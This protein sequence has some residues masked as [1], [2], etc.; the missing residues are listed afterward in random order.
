VPIT[1]PTVRPGGP[2]RAI[3]RLALVGLLLVPLVPRPI[4]RG[5]GEPPDHLVVS[6]VVT[7]AASASDEL[8]EL[9]NPT[10]LPLPLEGLELV[11]ASASG[12][13]VSRRAAWELGAPLVPA[14]GHVLVANQDGA[15]AAIADA[16]YASGIAATGGSV[17]IRIVGASSAIDAVGWGTATGALP[18]GSPAPAPA[19]GAS[20]ER[21]PGGAAGSAQDTGDNAADFAVREVPEPQNLAS[22]PTPSV[23]GDPGATPT[24]SP[25]PVPP[26]TQVPT[27]TP[28]ATTPIAAARALPDGAVATIE[29]VALAASDFHDGGGFVADASG[30]IAVLVTDGSFQRGTLLRVTGEVDDRFSQRTLRADGVAVVALGPGAEPGAQA[31]TTGGIGEAV[32]GRLVSVA[33]AVIGSA[34][35]LTSGVAYDLDDGTGPVR[36]LVDTATG[37]DTS[38]W[39]SGTRLDLVGVVGQRDSTG[40]G[41]SGYRVMPRD[42]ADVALVLP[43]SPSPGPSSPTASGSPSPEPTPA[44]GVASIATARAAPKNARVTVRGVVTLPTGVVDRQTAVIQDATGAIMLRLGGEAGTLALGTHVE[45]TGSR[46]TKSGMETLRVTQA[47]LP[48]GAGAA[49]EPRSLRTGDASEGHEATLVVVRGSIPASPRRAS[50][51]SVSF[52]LDDGSGALKVVL[53]AILVGDP[54]QLAAGSWVEV[55]GVLGQQTTGALPLE[56]YRLWPRTMSDLRVVAAPGGADGSRDDETG[57]GTATEPVGLDEIAAS[58]LADL[59][60]GATLVAGPWSELGIGGLLWDG[61]RLAAIDARSSELVSSLLGGRLP[62]VALELSG[63]RAIG[64]EPVTGIPLVM[65]GSGPGQT[66]TGGGPMAAPRS[67]IG[68]TPAWVTVLGR[69]AGTDPARIAL[70]GTRPVRV[71]LRCDTDDARVNRPV[72]IT[73]IAAGDP[74]RLIVPCHGLRPVPAISRNPV[75]AL[76]VLGKPSAPEAA[77]GTSSPSPAPLAAALL[78]AGAAM[79]GGSALAWRRRRALDGEAPAA[80]DEEPVPDERAEPP[81]LTLVSVPREHGP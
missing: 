32:E 20:I 36:V 58:D 33:G 16:T 60:I 30:G 52:D 79:L 10:S 72:S 78:L 55:R 47:P 80:T 71:D 26:S 34:T 29:G 73:G 1:V 67:G 54:A 65:L 14:G 38:A 81:R 46:S 61:S 37:I 9:H 51:G 69:M 59:R 76:A 50:S 7:G 2:V 11:Y 48:L 4:A 13:T 35:E 44:P 53:G 3:L 74:A 42:A 45:V 75:G 27:P 23:P 22:P 6:E 63:L 15:F 57:G 8:I 43:A 64:T 77:P 17:A 68:S 12:A 21:L 18:E 19:A 25:T 66:T 41:A 5:V 49:P 28:D 62:P 56:G 39:A 40:S 24:P 31:S 70:V